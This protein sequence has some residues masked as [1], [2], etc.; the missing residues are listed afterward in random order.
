LPE[1]NDVDDMDGSSVDYRPM[2]IIQDKWPSAS[3]N[4]HQI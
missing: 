1:H 3:K 2:S 4:Y